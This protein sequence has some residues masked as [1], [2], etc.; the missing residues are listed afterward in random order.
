MRVSVFD[1]GA[2]NLHSLAKALGH[3]GAFVEIET[4][5]AR[6][7]RTDVLVLPGIQIHP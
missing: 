1:Y 5:P 3:D 6:A 4:D 2:G 7:A